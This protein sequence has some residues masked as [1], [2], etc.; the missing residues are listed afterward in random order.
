MGSTINLGASL[1]DVIMGKSEP[2]NNSGEGNQDQYKEPHG[3]WEGYVRGGLEKRA[4]C[5]VNLDDTRVSDLDGEVHWG[6]QCGWLGGG[7]CA[8]GLG[9]G[10]P[11]EGAGRMLNRIG[12]AGGPH[13]ILELV[14]ASSRGREVSATRVTR[15]ANAG[16]KEKCLTPM[17]G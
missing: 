12:L 11:S 2:G 16:M 5:T 15:A 10:Q 6:V 13:W 14:Q 4:N 8:T 1:A 3:L 9:G 7:A 17:W